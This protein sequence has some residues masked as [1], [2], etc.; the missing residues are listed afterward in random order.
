MLSDSEFEAD[1]KLYDRLKKGAS[2]SENFTVSRAR[3]SCGIDAEALAV[4]RS[5]WLGVTT[6][7]TGGRPAKIIEFY[8]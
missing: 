2:G 7:K 3:N 8:R 1:S 4:K 6:K 5:S